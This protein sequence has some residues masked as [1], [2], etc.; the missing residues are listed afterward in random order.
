MC[1]PK[2]GKQRTE[3]GTLAPS[4]M[5]PVSVLPAAW[6]A[7]TSAIARSGAIKDWVDKEIPKWSYG[8]RHGVHTMDA[9]LELATRS[10]EDEFLGTADLSLAFDT[11]KPEAAIEMAEYLGFDPKVGRL[12]RE[13]WMDQ[14]RYINIGAGITKEPQK[15]R[16]SLPQG[17]ALSVVIMSVWLVAPAIDVARTMKARQVIFVDDR[18]WTTTDAT[19]CVQT[20]KKWAE[21]SRRMRMKEFEGKVQFWHKSGKGRK[22]LSEAGAKKEAMEEPFHALGTSMDGY[23]ARKDS[24]KEVARMEAAIATGSRCSRQ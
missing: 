18:S 19:T 2:Q 21:W 17:D 5:R 16:E 13:V 20:A 11:V 24:K 6:R 1:L 3:A 22:Q 9:I 4:A 12:L 15:V 23:K 14:E 7:I 10:D 8:G